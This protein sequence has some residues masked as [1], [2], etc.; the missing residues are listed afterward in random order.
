MSTEDLA[1]RALLNFLDGV[2][3]GAASARQSLKEEMVQENLDFNQLIW[4]TKE[5]AK[6]PFEQTTND[7]SS[8]FQALKRE[9]KTHQGFWK[10]NAA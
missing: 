9:L 7:G 8:L 5:G 3:A 1:L 6:G 2:E 4:E 10:H